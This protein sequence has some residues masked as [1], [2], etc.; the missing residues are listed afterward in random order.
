LVL[1][2]PEIKERK[3]RIL[4]EGLTCVY[5]DKIEEVAHYAKLA[6]EKGQ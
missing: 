2:N 6:L 5:K 4:V 1:P 3:D